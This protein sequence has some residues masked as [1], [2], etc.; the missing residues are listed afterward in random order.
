MQRR[1]YIRRRTR[2]A[3]RV[4][5]E[6]TKT[7]APRDLRKAFSLGYSPDRWLLEFVSPLA[8]RWG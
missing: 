2:S 5:V 7:A 1:G 8:V 6:I 3:D 4:R